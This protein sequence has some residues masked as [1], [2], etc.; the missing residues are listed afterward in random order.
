MNRY[1]YNLNVI[2]KYN[3]ILSD[4]IL[5]NR[6]IGLYWNFFFPYF[7]ILKIKTIYNK[8]IME[9]QV[10]TFEYGLVKETEA[11]G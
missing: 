11:K 6:K 4:D 1:S 3:F 8:N 5:I 9:N 2:F 7:Y 10:I